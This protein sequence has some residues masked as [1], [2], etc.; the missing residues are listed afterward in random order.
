MIAITQH[1]SQLPIYVLGNTHTV[2]FMQLTYEADIIAARQALFL[3][4]GQD[5]Y[6]DLLKTGEGI[7]KIK[8]RVSATHMRFPPIELTGG[9]VLDAELKRK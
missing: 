6:L 4:R 1:P 3:E 8:G 5:R 7:V 9:N 2:V